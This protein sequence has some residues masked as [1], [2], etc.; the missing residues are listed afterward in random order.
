MW[1]EVRSAISVS[2]QTA[3]VFVGARD[4]FVEMNS[5][6]GGEARYLEENRT[7]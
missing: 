6:F 1:Y 3:R 4:N 5:V 7:E 2:S